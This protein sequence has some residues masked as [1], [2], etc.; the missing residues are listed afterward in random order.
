MIDAHLHIGRDFVSDGRDTDEQMIL[1][2][3]EQ[4]HLNGCVVYPGNSNISKEVERK[5]N[6]EAAAFFQKYPE[7]IWGICQ[8]NPNY[9]EREFME[10]VLRYQQMGF[11]G[12]NINP[13][14]HGWDTRSHHG[15]IVFTVARETKMPLFINVGV[16][17]PF[18]QPVK[19]MNLCKKYYDVPVVLVHATKSYCG[20]QCDVLMQECPNTYLE[21]SLGPN[22]RSL[23]RYVKQFGAGRV[24]M[25]S[26]YIFHMEHSIYCFEH[27]GISGEEFDWATEKT[28]L[29]VLGIERGKA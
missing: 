26:C 25:G 3:L 19:L 12:I 23:N 15:E 24:I 29:K 7:K 1:E 13:Q 27:C 6:E 18:G 14:I 2:R 22:M 16:G 10:E 28:I 5:Q 20:S 17:L 9:E 4:C 11:R 8:L 21:T